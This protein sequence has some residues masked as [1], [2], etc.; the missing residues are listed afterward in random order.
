MNLCTQPNNLTFE[1]N[2]F[3]WFRR[4]KVA[5]WFIDGPNNFFFIQ[6][7]YYMLVRIEI[8]FK[9]WLYN[10]PH[11]R[12]LK[13]WLGLKCECVDHAFSLLY[14]S[15]IGVSIGSRCPLLRAKE[16][17]IWP[18]HVRR[19]I[20]VKRTSV[21]RIKHTFILPKVIAPHTIACTAGYCAVCY[22]SPMHIHTLACTHVMHVWK[23][24]RGDR[25]LCAHM[26]KS[27]S[28]SWE[29]VI[30]ATVVG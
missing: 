11:L 26:G 13:R 8:M 14:L 17:V 18:I 5:Q 20:E 27:I 24:V 6:I 3:H 21:L 29:R 25:A 2:E 15:P 28:C 16:S 9:R 10:E 23:P 30:V 19:N 4:R 1:Y 7:N 22:A 12:K